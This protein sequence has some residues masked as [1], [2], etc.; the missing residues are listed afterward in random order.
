MIVLT[1]W[2]G[3]ANYLK[4]NFCIFCGSKL[5]KGND[6]NQKDRHAGSCVLLA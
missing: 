1:G 3:L 5:E 4:M 6:E 2:T